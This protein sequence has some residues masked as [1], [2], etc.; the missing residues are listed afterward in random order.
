MRIWLNHWFS[1][2]YRLIENAK[3]DFIEIF[4]DKRVEFIGTNAKEDCVYKLMCNEFY[5]EPEGLNEEQYIGWCL[6]FCTTHKIDVFVP[7]RNMVWVSK[8]L[9]EFEERGIKVLVIHNYE[10][11]NMLN[12]KYLTYSNVKNLP[13]PEHFC[14]NTLEEFEK[15]YADLKTPSNRV[16]IK[17]ARGEGATSFRVIDDRMSGIESLE[18]GSGAKISYKDVCEMLGSVDRFDDLLVLPY[19]IGPEVSIDCLQTNKGLIAVPRMKEGRVTKITFESD[20]LMLADK[21]A[22]DFKIE[23]PYNLQ[24]RWHNGIPYLLEVNTR[25]SGGSH[26]ADKV[27]VN[28]L[29]LAIEQ[30]VKGDISKFPDIKKLDMKVTQIETPIVL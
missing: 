20:L 25:M 1:T 22:R 12:D 13:I 5:V 2:A 17:Y 27:G 19:L 23:G 30:L 10:L 3:R 11:M 26:I 4:P 24:I 7:R 18:L 14:V 8:H 9:N 15:A 6:G 28:F 29:A 21:F 16:C